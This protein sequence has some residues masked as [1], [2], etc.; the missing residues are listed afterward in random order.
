MRTTEIVKE[1]M[2]KKE[3]KPSVMA[4]RLGISNQ[5]M[6]DRLKHLRGVNNF[7]AC[8]TQLDYKVVAVPI[9]TRIK[10]D[11]YEVTEE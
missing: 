10:D 7:N 6:N 3:M 8:L 5:A 2:G 4:R 1:L 9:S 11:W